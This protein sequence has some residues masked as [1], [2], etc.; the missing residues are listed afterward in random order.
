[1]LYVTTARENLT[2]DQLTRAPLSGSVLVVVPGILG[3]PPSFF[4]G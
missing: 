4:A 2:A 3:L 1:V